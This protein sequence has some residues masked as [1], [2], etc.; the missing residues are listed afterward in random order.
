MAQPFRLCSSPFPPTRRLPKRASPPPSFRTEQADVPS[1]RFAPVNRLACAVR[2]LSSSFAYSFGCLV[3][4][5]LPCSTRKR[6]CQRNRRYVTCR[7]VRFPRIVSEVFL[8]H[9]NGFDRTHSTG[10]ACHPVPSRNTEQLP[11]HQ[12]AVGKA[13]S[14][15]QTRSVALHA[16]SVFVPFIVYALF[17]ANAPYAIYACADF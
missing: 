2:N 14:P 8:N 1:S 5:L 10:H 9:T 12:K 7:A 16:G 15:A 6:P 4:L 3:F 17:T 11:V 13:C